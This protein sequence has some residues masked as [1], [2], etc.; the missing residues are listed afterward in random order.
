MLTVDDV[1]SIGD[2]L[3]ADSRLIVKVAIVSFK[4]G[5]RSSD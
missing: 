5:E 4:L 1:D 3:K 2:L